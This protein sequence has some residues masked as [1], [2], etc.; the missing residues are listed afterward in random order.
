M[1]STPSAPRTRPHVV[2][3]GGGPAAQR[4]TEALIARDPGLELT[5]VTEEPV[6]PYDRVALS[7]IGRAHV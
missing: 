1:A 6:A 5:V 7:Q 2:V 3:V 4:F